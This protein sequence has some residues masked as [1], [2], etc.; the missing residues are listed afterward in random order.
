MAPRQQELHREGLQPPGWRPKLDPNDPPQYAEARAL[1]HAQAEAIFAK[2][3]A[4]RFKHEVEGLAESLAEAGGTAGLPIGSSVCL[5]ID[6]VGRD[7]KPRAIAVT[8]WPL[9]PMT[10]EEVVRSGALKRHV[11]ERLVKEAGLGYLVKMQYV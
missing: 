8:L 3:E 1:G 11:Y 4:E 10:I 5:S 2:A 9:E 6:P 7:K